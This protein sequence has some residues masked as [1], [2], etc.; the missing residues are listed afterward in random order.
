M[1]AFQMASS[2]IKTLPYVRLKIVCTDAS[3]MGSLL[4]DDL[5][6][7][8]NSQIPCRERQI[9]QVAALLDVSLHCLRLYPNADLI[10]AQLT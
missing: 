9:R 8:L 1:I 3:T 6:L 10:V 2:V 4:P 7:S 5:L